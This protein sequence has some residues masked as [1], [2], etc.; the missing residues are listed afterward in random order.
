MKYDFQRFNNYLFPFNLFN[1][2]D[3][4]NNK[5]GKNI[6]KKNNNCKNAKGI[7]VWSEKMHETQNF[8]K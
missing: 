3:N 2:Y 5:N 6:I 7:V 8:Y 1:K 4:N